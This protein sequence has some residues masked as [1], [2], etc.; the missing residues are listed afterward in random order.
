MSASP[1]SMDPHTS[2][3]G[4]DPLYDP[5]ASS[6][7]R[8][9]ATLTHLS[10]LTS[11]FFVPVLVG[12]VMWLARRNQSPFI[13]DHGKESL[14]F[15]ISLVIYMI[16][17]FAL[18]ALTCVGIVLVPVVY[19]LGLVGMVLAAQA[20]SNGKYYRYPACIRFVG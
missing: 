8:T 11:L 15:Q 6:D 16:G 13:D 14:N 19:V 17:A 2:H 18:A 12:L 7:E 3:P 4:A 9:Y 1:A 20:A 5:H 10:L